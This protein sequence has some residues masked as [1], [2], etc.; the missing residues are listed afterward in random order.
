MSERITEEEYRRWL[1]PR[2]ARATLADHGMPLEIAAKTIPRRVLTTDITAVAERKITF[3][4]GSQDPEEEA[5]AIVTPDE[6]QSSALDVQFWLTGDVT[7]IKESQLNRQSVYTCTGIRFKPSGIHKLLDQLAQ[8]PAAP[9]ALAKAIREH[10]PPL[11]SAVEQATSAS[12]ANPSAEKKP[13]SDATLRA[14]WDLCRTLKP[15]DQWDIDE[16]REFFDQCLPDKFASRD[17][18]RQV[19]GPQKSGPKSQAAE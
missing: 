6:W 8:P 19:R 4:A 10:S 12:R 15:T 3:R 2:Q 11:P 9:A 16:L 14:W 5:F 1:S 18:I 13:V 7:F 17:R